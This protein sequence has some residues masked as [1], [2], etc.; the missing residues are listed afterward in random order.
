AALSM[1]NQGDKADAL[2]QRWL[3]EAQVPGDLTPPQTARLHAAVS[4]MLGNVHHF[5]SD[6]LEERWL[7][8]LAQ[9]ALFFVRRD[10][11]EPTVDRIVTDHRFGRREEARDLRKQFAKILSAKVATLAPNFLRRIAGWAEADDIAP[12]E[13]KRIA[14]VVRKR[15]ENAVKEHDKHE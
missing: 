9:T 11:E 12:A 2:A 6:R 7:A 10:G 13:W 15:W 8:P 3:K 5:H 14:G 1:S 4:V